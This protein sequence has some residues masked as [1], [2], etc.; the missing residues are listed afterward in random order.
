PQLRVGAERVAASLA[1]SGPWGAAACAEPGER[2]GLGI[3]IEDAGAFANS[4]T[5]AADFAAT[6]LGPA[7]LD[8]YR[9]AAAGSEEARLGLLLIAW[10]RKEAVVKA[11]RTGFDT[12]RGGVDP[13][14][15]EV[16]APWEA[17]RALGPRWAGTVLWDLAPG[18]GRRPAPG[19]AGAQRSGADAHLGDAPLGDPRLAGQLLGNGAG[20]SGAHGDG[21]HDSAARGD[22]ARGNGMHDDGARGSGP[23]D[24]GTGGGGTG[25]GPGLRSGVHRSGAVAALAW[26]AEPVSGDR[27]T[28][29]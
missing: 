19:G 12:A 7:E 23:A 22:R 17:P 21:A 9:A 6:V 27:S 13:R 25:G 2:G 29:D 18:E 28:G 1:R 5:R 8:W 16:S 24:V 15:V 4:G 3:D 26:R 11:S 20:G 14:D 10:V